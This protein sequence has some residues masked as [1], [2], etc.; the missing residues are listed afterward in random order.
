MGGYGV[1]DNYQG[2]YRGFPL[3]NRAQCIRA[4]GVTAGCRAI[5]YDDRWKQCWLLTHPAY[6]DDRGDWTGYICEEFRQDCI[7]QWST[8]DSH[9]ERTY[10]ITR[11]KLNGGRDCDFTP[12]PPCRHGQDACPVRDCL[13]FGNCVHPTLNLGSSVICSGTTCGESECC[14]PRATCD[15]M[16]NTITCSHPSLRRGASTECPGDSQTCNAPIC[17]AAP[18]TCDSMASTVTCSHPS[19]RLGDT[20][21]C[22]GDFQTCNED[23]CCA[24]PATCDSMASTVTCSHPSLRLGSSTECLGDSQTCNADSCCAPPARCESLQCSDPTLHKGNTQVC[25][26]L[27][28]EI[29]E[30][31]DEPSLPHCTNDRNTFNAD[32][33]DCTTYL[34]GHLTN[35]FHYCDEDHKD[36]IWA[37][38]TC[39]ECGQ[40]VDAI[41]PICSGNRNTFD[42]GYG[43][44]T[45]YVEGRPNSNFNWCKTDAHD[46]IIAS[47]T[48]FECGECI[49]HDQCIQVSGA[50]PAL[51]ATNGIYRPHSDVSSHGE[52]TW[53]NADGSYYVFWNN[54]YGRG[55]Y[56]IDSDLDAELRVVIFNSHDKS[57]PVTSGL[58]WY[59]GALHEQSGSRIEMVTCP[60]TCASFTG[61]CRDSSLLKDS[62]T[63]CSGSICTQY[64]CCNEPSCNGGRNTYNVGYGD[65]TTYAEGNPSNNFAHC[66][67]DQDNGFLALHICSECGVCVN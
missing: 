61:T 20:T 30:C 45:S 33:G 37:K 6:F 39:S 40:C 57:L 13:T 10:T 1:A 7:V 51:S 49:D 52:K 65:C 5:M 36:G 62:S 41:L 25:Q 3:E 38:D 31:C 23:S 9:C 19:L 43:D 48:C 47:L 44:C 58:F 2:K 29:S 46:N 8:C 17:C 50:A 64:D 32:H 28:C 35:N 4:C 60:V 54:M 66:D 16:A 53:V 55:E 59:S 63:V 67:N 15:S 14:R 18:A 12:P 22:P 56:Q 24:P 34:E 11:E 27:Q 42:A 21:E 26:G